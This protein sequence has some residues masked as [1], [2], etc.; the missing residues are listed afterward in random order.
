MSVPMLAGAVAFSSSSAADVVDPDGAGVAA[1]RGVR[2]GRAFPLMIQVSRAPL[3]RGPF[4]FHCW[5]GTAISVGQ[6][7]RLVLSMGF[8][9][10]GVLVI[11]VP[12]VGKISQLQQWLQALQGFRR[13]R[14]FSQSTIKCCTA[15]FFPMQVGNFSSFL[16][17]HTNSNQHHHTWQ[18]LRFFKINSTPHCGELGL[19]AG[20][21]AFGG[22]SRLASSAPYFCGCFT[23]PHTKRKLSKK[24]GKLIPEPSGMCAFLTLAD[25]ESWKPDD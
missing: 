21:Y 13:R 7:S 22:S 9:W 11:L 8:R 2:P 12:V 19:P 20:E 3:M 5:L 10:S 14:C 15:H 23:L 18:F 25:V 17:R 24:S 4:G 1:V 6:A 16:E